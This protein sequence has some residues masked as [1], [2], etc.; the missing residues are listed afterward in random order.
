MKTHQILYCARCMDFLKWILIT[1][2]S[3]LALNLQFFQSITNVDLIPL[4]IILYCAVYFLYLSKKRIYMASLPMIVGIVFAFINPTVSFYVIGIGLLLMEIFFLTY[5][6][7]LH[8][9]FSFGNIFLSKYIEKC[10]LILLNIVIIL[11]NISS[12]SFSA[13]AL[14]IYIL[15]FIP[16]STLTFL[17]KKYDEKYFL[18]KDYIFVSLLFILSSIII[19]P[20][21]LLPSSLLLIGI[22]FTLMAFKYYNELKVRLTFLIAHLFTSIG[23]LVFAYVDLLVAIIFVATELILIAIERLL[24]NKIN[25]VI[26][27]RF[28]ILMKLD[29]IFNVSLILIAVSLICSQFIFKDILLLI[30]L[31]L[32]MISLLYSIVLN[33]YRFKDIYTTI[34]NSRKII[35]LEIE[36]IKSLN[37]KEIE[38]QI[39][40][41]LVEKEDLKNQMQFAVKFIK[42][43]QYG[44]TYNQT[45]NKFRNLFE[46]YY[47]KHVLI[48][49]CF[50]L[51]KHNE[52]LILKILK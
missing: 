52:N 51:I 22:A 34:D 3:I 9:K 1:L 43:R 44:N 40:Q 35:N 13:V 12:Y 19:W 37:K 14:I 23:I 4:F 32:L 16:F 38:K 47:K 21:N 8:I 26:C 29:L 17:N 27:E 33:Y 30:N 49:Y 42:K 6:M 31:I 2:T 36:K 24:D 50:P 45:A 10:I 18:I 46:N 41:F 39:Q 5:S 48:S 25:F 28:H 20:N 15:A 7:L 11:C